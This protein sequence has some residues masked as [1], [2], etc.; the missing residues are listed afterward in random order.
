MDQFEWNE[1]F[2]FSSFGFERQPISITHARHMYPKKE[3]MFFLWFLVLR[4]MPT[5]VGVGNSKE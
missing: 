2:V 3:E 4:Y 5:K 1:I